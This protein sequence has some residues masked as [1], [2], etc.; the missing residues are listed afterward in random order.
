MTATLASVSR[1]IG[2]L[3]ERDSPDTVPVSVRDH[4]LTASSLITDYIGMPL[5]GSGEDTVLHFD[6]DRGF[7]TV[8]LTLPT[9]SKNPL[10]S[11]DLPLTGVL[12]GLQVRYRGEVDADTPTDWTHP[13]TLLTPGTDYEHDAPNGRIRLLFQPE[14]RISGLQVRYGTRN[15]SRPDIMVGEDLRNAISRMVITVQGTF[16]G[17]HAKVFAGVPHKKAADCLTVPEGSGYSVQ[18]VEGLGVASLT[19]HGPR[20]SAMSLANF[21]V[22]FQRAGGDESTGTL[23]PV[24][25]MR[26]TYAYPE[27]SP[28][29]TGG[30]LAGGTILL[31]KIVP[32]F[33][34]PTW[35]HAEGIVPETVSHA[36]ALFARTLMQ[37]GELDGIGKTSDKTRRSYTSTA[38]IPAEIRDMLA[39]HRRG[40]SAVTMI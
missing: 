3:S 28:V 37:K 24:M 7:R 31:S 19:L 25:G 10:P 36:C 39:S 27:A 14:S 15:T 9:F 29:M 20:D 22:L 23:T 5:L 6:T 13:D 18:S 35:R 26:L 38:A 12:P 34:H 30:F 21:D 32:L 40:S 4:L 8:G 2:M 33:Y 1:L 11:F 16:D 17:P